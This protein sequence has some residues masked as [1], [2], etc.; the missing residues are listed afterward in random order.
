M[1]APPMLGAGY[2]A[3]FNEDW[4]VL[5]CTGWSRA[6][7]GRSS[8]G[9]KLMFVV[10][11]IPSRALAGASVAVVMSILTAIEIDR[12]LAL[13][14]AVLGE[15]SE[16]IVPG[17]DCDAVS[18]LYR[19][20]THSLDLILCGKNPGMRGVTVPFVRERSTASIVPWM[21]TKGIA[22]MSK[23]AMTLGKTV[24]VGLFV[25]LRR[26][27]TAGYA[28]MGTDF[29]DWNFSVCVSGWDFDVGFCS[30]EA[31]RYGDRPAI[32]LSGARTL[33]SK[34]TNGCRRSPPS[35]YGC[36]GGSLA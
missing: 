1:V 22:S 36:G 15:A 16:A 27:C 34:P 6:P 4:R 35:S 31:G 29:F 2:G 10:H 17:G 19:H 18:S 7:E 25:Y 26:A 3:K 5:G 28:L 23:E 21:E 33:C 8:D 13:P 11:D 9:L 24:R 30:R 14:W 20:V 12:T 32:G